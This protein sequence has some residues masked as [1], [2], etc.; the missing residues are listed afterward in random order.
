MLQEGIFFHQVKTIKDMKY[1]LK[2]SAV[3]WY[4]PGAVFQEG[5]VSRKRIDSVLK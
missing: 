5:I 1:K 3:V 4:N 2:P